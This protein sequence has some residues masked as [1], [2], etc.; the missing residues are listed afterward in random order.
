MGTRIVVL[1]GSAALL[2]GACMM[3]PP[4]G[5]NDRG[6]ERTYR[7]LEETGN[8]YGTAETITPSGTIDRTNPFFLALGTNPR[9]CETCHASSQGWTITA[10]RSKELFQQSAGLDPL[11]NLVDTGVRPDADVSTEDARKETFKPVTDRGLVRFTRNINT[12]NAEFVVT[13]VVDPSG[14]SDTAHILSFRRPSPTANETKV[15]SLLWTGGP[16]TDV[17]VSAG[18]VLTGGVRLHEQGVVAPTADQVTAAGT[19]MASVI[20][21]QVTAVDAGRLDAAGALGGPVN[22]AAQTFYAGINDIQGHD[23]AGPFDHRVF[24]LYDAWSIYADADGSDPVAARR[25][26]IYRG[27]EIFNN[28]EFDITGVVGINDVLGQATVRGT[29]SLCHNAPNVGVHSVFRM[30]STGTADPANCNAVDPQI[31]VQNKTTA[32]TRTVCDLGRATSTGKWAD[33]G[34]FRA[35]PLRGAAGRAPY[36]HDG[37]A[38]DLEKVIDFYN[39]RFH[40]GFRQDQQDDL[41]KFLGAL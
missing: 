9:S 22:L 27:Q 26:A 12:T 38:K 8:E 11:F 32:E 1:G 15:P 24:N 19:F 5:G 7:A 31:T 23:S 34:A 20:F 3:E 14:F 36:F 13:S 41:D 2:L 21:A 6:A 40:I 35:P 28:L 25:G 29:C 16:I 18:G 10:E 33:L 4:A 30:F 39:H 17:V 37:Q